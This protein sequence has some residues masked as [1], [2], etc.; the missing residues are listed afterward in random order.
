MGCPNLDD[1]GWLLCC[2]D[3]GCAFCSTSTEGIEPS[4]EFSKK[5]VLLILN[6]TNDSAILL[7]QR[8][9]HQILRILRKRIT[10]L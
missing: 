10:I 2:V 4:E 6:P 3:L 7:H 1:P 9:Y 5:H 8:Q